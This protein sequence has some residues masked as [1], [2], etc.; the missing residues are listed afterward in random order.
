[1]KYRLTKN[2]GK[3][4]SVKNKPDTLKYISTD[5]LAAMLNECAADEVNGNRGRDHALLFC[6]FWLGLRI[7][8]AVAITTESF[9]FLKDGQITVKRLKQ[10]GE[11]KF[12]PLAFVPAPVAKY[13]KAYLG[14]LRADQR[15]LFETR[16]GQH[17]SSRTASRIFDTYAE[18][19][20]LPAEYSF[21]ALRHGL[22]V[23]TYERTESVQAV[24]EMLGHKD[25]RAS[26]FYIRISPKLREKY[27]SQFQ[28][29]M[30][31]FETP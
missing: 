23:L 28:G 4:G 9:A 19:A 2:L 18:Q 13:I 25:L 11:Q 29:S 22:G 6:G 17:I 20:G 16:P 26:E 3:P 14:K 27:Q 24:K 21:H 12:K 31:E 1:M 15:F 8:E 7:G 5:Q 30:P 10:R